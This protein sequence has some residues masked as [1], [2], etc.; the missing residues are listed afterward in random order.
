MLFCTLSPAVPRSRRRSAPGA[1]ALRLGAQSRGLRLLDREDLLGLVDA[2]PLDDPADHDDEHEHETGKGEAAAQPAD[3]HPLE[4]PRREDVDGGQL[5][6]QLVLL[7]CLGVRLRLGVRRLP[8]FL[9]ARV[10]LAGRSAVSSAVAAPVR[11]SAT[12]VHRPAGSRGR[13]GRRR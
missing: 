4:D 6:N 3:G 12:P 10:A 1:S 2:Q 9:S 5:G 8:A 7:L 13:A 11:H